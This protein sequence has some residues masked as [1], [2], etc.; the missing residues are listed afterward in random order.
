LSKACQMDQVSLASVIMRLL[1]RGQRV[2]DH[3]AG[4]DQETLLFN[5]VRP[6]SSCGVFRGN[7]CLS[8]M[9]RPIRIY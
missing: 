9:M 8:A 6:L 4:S 2:C 5:T 1:C 7:Y 3:L